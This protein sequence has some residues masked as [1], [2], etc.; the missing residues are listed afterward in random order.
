MHVVDLAERPGADE[1]PRLLE[2]ADEAVVVAD[3]VDALALRWPARTSARSRL[4]EASAASR[5]R[6]ASPCSSAYWRGEVGGGGGG[7]EH[8][9]ERGARRSSSRKSLKVSTPV[10]FFRTESDVARGVADR[11]DRRV[12]QRVGDGEVGQPHLPAADDADSDSHASVC[13]PEDTPRGS[14][15][16]PSIETLGR[17]ST[18]KPIPESLLRF[19][20]L[21]FTLSLTR[22]SRFKV[23]TRRVVLRSRCRQRARHP[24][25]C[26]S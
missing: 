1:A 21:G 19:S 17:F 24:R 9:V 11:D 13:S 3:L 16:K 20:K 15:M 4:G 12:R 23:Q 7:D 26:G 14:G 10:Y 8:R 18:S 22:W 5:R 25:N 2:G 6:R